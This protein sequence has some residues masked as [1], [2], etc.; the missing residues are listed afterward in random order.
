VPGAGARALQRGGHSL[1]RSPLMIIFWARLV[2]ES[3]RLAI[4]RELRP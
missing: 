1:K 2:Q 4:G 3:I